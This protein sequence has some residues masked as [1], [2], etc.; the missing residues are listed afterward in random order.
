MTGVVSIEVLL[1]DR[2]EASV[3]EDW[4]RLADA[5]LSSLAPHRSPSNRPHVTLLVRPELAPT[6]FAGAVARLPVALE[7][8]EPLT[9]VHG[10]RA[11]L[12]WRVTLSH[13]LDRLHRTVHAEAPPGEDA[14][15][16]AP[17]GWTPHI[18]LA[19][20]VRVEALPDARALLGRPRAGAGVALR[21]WDSATKTVTPL[22]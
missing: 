13:Q 9:F 18:T 6:D 8:A 10:D 3:R 7:L 14:A 4:E 20:R 15:H 12:A 16:T 11:V 1:D 19:R 17:G 21:R 2:T 5:G 22:G